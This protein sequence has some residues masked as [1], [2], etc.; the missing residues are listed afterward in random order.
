VAT[1]S[2]AALA[3]GTHVV[4]AS[5]AGDTNNGPSMS[6]A[7]SQ[8]VELIPTTTS[9][10]PSPAPSSTGAGTITLEASVAG[11]IGPM[12]G[13]TVTFTVG[14][15]TLGSTTLD[16][17][18]TA[19]LTPTLAAGTYTVIASYGGDALH[20]PS[21]SQA[22]SVEQ[23]LSAFTLSVAPSTVD[24]ETNQSATTTVTLASTGGFTDTIA[25]A[26]SGLP[27]GVTCQVSSASVLLA[28]NDVSTSQL[29]L[30]AGNTVS[31]S[32]TTGSLRLAGGV[33]LA[34]ISLSGLLLP[35]GLVSG[36]LFAP[37]S[38]RRS[39]H[40]VALLALGCAALLATGCTTIHLN[41]K[42]TQSYTF[43]VTGTGAASNTTQSATVTLNVSQ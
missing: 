15:T 33:S 30:I 3:P 28:A 41:A 40:I 7:I 32:S 38:R 1:L 35:F 13:G 31:S 5:Y 2:S 24:I 10:T 8:V 18:A 6:L 29:T 34:G 36:C 12:P 21:T 11:S 42:N 14:T 22:V 26:C 37:P 16:A 23:A 39:L 20:A 43:Q 19:T 17:N 27:T 9:L 25:L 4:S